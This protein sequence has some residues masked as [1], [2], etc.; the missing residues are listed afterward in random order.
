MRERNRLEAGIKDIDAVE[1]E[2]TDSVELIE[3]GEAE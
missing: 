2:L 1:R 3:M